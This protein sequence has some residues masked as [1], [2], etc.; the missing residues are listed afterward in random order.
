MFDEQD[1]QALININL[2]L[3]QKIIK[4][5]KEISQKKYLI[6]GNERLLFIMCNH[7]WEY[8][9]S[10]NFDDATK[11]QCKKCRLWNNRFMYC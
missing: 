5:N 1:S 2:K 7:E 10:C 9:F 3:E 11:Y 6:K 4:L 8:D